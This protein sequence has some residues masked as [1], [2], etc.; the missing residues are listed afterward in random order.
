MM[1]VALMTLVCLGAS[2]QESL[3]QK[4]IEEYVSKMAPVIRNAKQGEYALK[5]NNDEV[6]AKFEKLSLEDKYRV[7]QV[8]LQM[9]GKPEFAIPFQR[10]MRVI[11]LASNMFDEPKLDA[12]V[13]DYIA[14]NKELKQLIIDGL[15]ATKL[16]KLNKLKVGMIFLRIGNSEHSLKYLTS[17]KN[18]YSDGKRDLAKMSREDRLWLKYYFDLGKI[19]ESDREAATKEFY[20]V[21]SD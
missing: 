4:D 19:Q 15:D 21:F 17:V 18:V 12:W 16:S 3:T 8:N 6:F 9:H 10:V 13:T 5:L 11:A 14:M 7:I 2:P 1:T 20:P